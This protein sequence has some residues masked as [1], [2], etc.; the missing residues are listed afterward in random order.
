MFISVSGN[1]ETWPSA[2]CR[3]EETLGVGPDGLGCNKD[4]R[5]F[6]CMF[7]VETMFRNFY[8]ELGEVN[9]QGSAQR[10]FGT[11]PFDTQLACPII[12]VLQPDSGNCSAPRDSQGSP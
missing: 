11:T 3:E 10:G 9:H 12:S 4:S 7:K 1:V 6:G 5:S 2:R 8:G